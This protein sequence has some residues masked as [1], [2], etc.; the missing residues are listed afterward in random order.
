MGYNTYQQNEM[1][2]VPGPRTGDRT[3]ET[4]K[5]INHIEINYAVKIDPIHGYKGT[6]SVV[7]TRVN[8]GP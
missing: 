8:S 5:N 6:T 7:P 1:R 2:L 4:N 3:R